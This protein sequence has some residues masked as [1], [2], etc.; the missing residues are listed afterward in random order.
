MENI[1]LTETDDFS[2]FYL[3]LFMNFGIKKVLKLEK[4]EYF[5]VYKLPSLKNKKKERFNKKIIKYLKKSGIKN[6]C[7]GKISE[8]LKSEIY[9]NFEI[10]TGENTFYENIHIIIDFFAKKKGIKL[11]EN[12]VCFILDN[13]ELVKSLILKCEN[14]VKSFSVLTD[15]EE[16]FHDLK[17]YLSENKGIFLKINEKK[18]KINTIYINCEK[19]IKN[20]EDLIIKTNTIDIFKIYKNTYNSVKLFYKTNDNKFIENN[21]I[22]KN[23]IFTDFL[24]KC[25]KKTPENIKIVNIKKYDW[26]IDLFQL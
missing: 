7:C 10:I 5:D 6:I 25:L 15:K 24:T 26:Q 22:E 21:K 18:K 4:G 9:K 8:D 19:K 20:I 16:L 13:P 2:K 14:K 1:Y 12:E 23:I 11:K 17:D 3:F